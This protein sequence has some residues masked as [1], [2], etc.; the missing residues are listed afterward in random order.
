MKLRILFIL[1]FVSGSLGWQI[2]IATVSIKETHPAGLS[3]R[4]ANATIWHHAQAQ[5][6]ELERI[7]MSS[8]HQDKRVIKR[9]IYA[10]IQRHLSNVRRELHAMKLPLPPLE[11]SNTDLFDLPRLYND[12]SEVAFSAHDRDRKRC[13]LIQLVNLHQQA[14]HDH[15]RHLLMAPDLIW[16]SGTFWSDSMRIGQHQL[17]GGS[18][19]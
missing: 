4:L 8:D 11:S 18:H 19:R 6:L 17:E 10:A 5:R 16:S 2:A 9:R 12:V 3:Y 7:I 13:E 14:A 15:L 1:C